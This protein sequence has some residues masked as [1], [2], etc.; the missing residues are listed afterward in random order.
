MHFGMCF[1]HLVCISPLL[2]SATYNK[3]QN[4]DE[5]RLENESSKYENESYRNR[6]RAS[7]KSESQTYR[8][9]S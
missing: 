1:V 9:R 5:F 3:D 7:G 8:N 6:T 4:I 2:L